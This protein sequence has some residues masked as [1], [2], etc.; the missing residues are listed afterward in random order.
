[1]LGVLFL[2][3]TVALVTANSVQSV[4]LMNSLKMCNMQKAIH[5]MVLRHWASQCQNM[6]GLKMASKTGCRYSLFCTLVLLSQTSPGLTDLRAGL[7]L[8]NRCVSCCPIGKFE[9]NVQY[10]HY[11]IHCS[12]IQPDVMVE[13][14]CVAKKKL[15]HIL[16]FYFE[17]YIILK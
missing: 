6:Y 12:D 8:K 4:S 2:Q 7:N 5:E 15:Q 11:Q 17:I 10:Q 13:S 3:H 16:S 9:R 14:S 1:M